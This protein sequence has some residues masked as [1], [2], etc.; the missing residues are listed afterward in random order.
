MT[1]PAYAVIN[2]NV[3]NS[4]QYEQYRILSGQAMGEYGAEILVRGGTQIVLEGAFHPRTVLL[5]FPSFEKAQA[6]YDSPA[7]VAARA[8]RQGVAMVDFMIVEGVA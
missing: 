7:Y 1:H 6:F 8:L 3:I 5:K 4:E 2:V